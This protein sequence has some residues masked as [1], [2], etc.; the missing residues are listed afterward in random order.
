VI[1]KILFVD[2]EPNVLVSFKRH[3]RK[4]FQ[5]ETAQM[6]FDAVNEGTVFRFLIKP[7]PLETLVKALKAGIAQ[8]QL[9]TAERELLEKTVKGSIEVLTEVLGMVNPVAFSRATRIKHYVRDI[10]VQLQLP[11]LWQLEVAAMLSQIGCITL[12]S[13]ILEKIDAGEALTDD[14]QR[15]FSSHPLVGNELVANIPRLEPAARMIGGQL[16]PFKSY[17]ARHKSAQERE[18]ALGAQIL[19]VAVDLDQMVASGLSPRDALAEQRRRP[20]VYNTEVATALSEAQ[21]LT[22]SFFAE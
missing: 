7:C 2:D 11:N 21:G 3:L 18:I 8:Y 10:A 5:I 1:E 16:R 14:E 6:A 9:V 17:A 22:T 15:S 20:D 12:P 19:K 4:Q 13:E